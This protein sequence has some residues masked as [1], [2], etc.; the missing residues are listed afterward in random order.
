MDHAKANLLEGLH[1]LR[2]RIDSQKDFQ[3]MPE[4]RKESYEI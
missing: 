4:T 3:H 1:A 2:S